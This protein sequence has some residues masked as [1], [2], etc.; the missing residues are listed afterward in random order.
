MHNYSDAGVKYLLDIIQTII[1][2]YFYKSIKLD[3]YQMEIF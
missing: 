1:C 2:R 3:S